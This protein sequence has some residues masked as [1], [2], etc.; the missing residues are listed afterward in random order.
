[1]KLFL[2]L[3]LFASVIAFSMPS[4]AGNINN[5]VS[6]QVNW[7]G[8]QPWTVRQFNNFS[9]YG[10]YLGGF[11]RFYG[12]YGFARYSPFN[13]SAVLRRNVSLPIPNYREKMKLNQSLAIISEQKKFQYL[14]IKEKQAKIKQMELPAIQKT[15]PTIQ[16]K[17]S[18]KSEYKPKETIISA[19]QTVVMN[20][21]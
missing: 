19:D 17:E 5:P 11:G 12:G 10:G 18:P 6:F 4:M 9:Y 20:L 21:Y 14:A 8:P 7:S 16:L 3:V 2:F 15:T 1:M 13:Y